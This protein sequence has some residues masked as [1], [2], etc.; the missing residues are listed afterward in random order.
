LA[1]VRGVF[2]CYLA[3]RVYPWDA[4]APSGRPTMEQTRWQFPGAFALGMDLPIYAEVAEDFRSARAS[5]GPV[6]FG[7][8]SDSPVPAQLAERFSV[9]SV[10]AMAVYPKLDK[11]YLFG[12]H[13]C[14]YP[15][16]WTAA[17]ERLF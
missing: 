13:Q 10:L 4:A 12:L 8:G 16:A 5:S 3:G 14:S 17:E 7:P 1:A 9:H 2:E 15:R 11:P 6:R